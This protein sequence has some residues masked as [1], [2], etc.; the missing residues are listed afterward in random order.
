MLLGQEKNPGPGTHIIVGT[1]TDYPPYS[2]SENGQPT[3]FNVELTQAIAEVMGLD[4]EIRMRPWA[5]IRQSLED[6]KIQVVSG[7]AYSEDRARLVGFSPPYTII[8]HAIFARRHSPAVRSVEE[9][10]GKELI[11]MRGD[12]MH[13]YV[14]EAN[15]T[16]KIVV[17]DTQ[18][19]A[20]RLLASGQHDYA[21]VAKLPGLYWVQELKLKNVVTVGP[22]L[23]QSRYSYAVP[24]GDAAMLG[25][26]SEGLAILKQTGRYQELY[27]KWLGVL[28]PSGFS[29]AREFKYLA[30]ILAPI[31][32]ILAGALVWSRS[33]QKQVMSRTAELK[34]EVNER[35]RAQEELES[36]N[37]ALE[38]RVSERTAELSRLNAR[39]ELAVRGSN[40]GLWE[41][42]IPGGVY[43]NGRWN[44]IN[45]WEL[46]GYDR[47]ETPTTFSAWMDCVHA[48][49]RARLLCTVQAYL[50]GETNRY[51][52]EY[53]I[54][55]KDGQYRWVLS[56]GVAVRNAE[57]KP[58]RFIG[59][60]VDIT[61]RKQ[62]EAALRE[63]EERFRGFF[64]QTIVGIAQV[65]LDGRFVQ[66]NRRYCE[67]VGRS[68][69]ELYRSKMQEITHPDDLPRNLSLF[70]QLT[71]G[72]PSF[73]IEKRYIRPDGSLVWVNNCVSAL[74]DE[75]GTPSSNFAVVLD[76]TERKQVEEALRVAKARLDIAIRASN[77]GFTEWDMPDA[78][79]ARRTVRFIN[80][81]EQIGYDAANPPSS[82]VIDF[83]H[84]DD[85]DRLGREIEA[86]LYGQSKELE[87][88][89]RLRHKDGSYRWMLGR[90][91]AE[92]DGFGK[93]LRFTGSIVDITE[94]KRA[95]AALREAKE[96]A[97]SANR[98]KDEFLANVSHEIRT[99]MNAILGMTELV[100]DTP[101]TEDQRQCLKTAQSAADNL[102]GIIN[103]LLDF[104]K[105]EAGKL[106]LDAADFSLRAV[107]EEPLR[108][109]A[110]RAHRK[111]LELVCHVLPDVPDALVGDVGRLRQVL[112]NLIGNAIKFTEHGEVVLRV[113]VATEEPAVAA[114]AVMGVRFAVSDTGIGIPLANQEKI[115][116]AFE[117]EDTATTRKYGGTG[118]GLTIA[119]RLVALMGGAIAVDSAPGRGSTFSFTA[120]FARQARSPKPPT[121]RPLALI[122]D[123]QVLVVDDNA[124]NSRILV[125]W[126]RN[127]Q[128]EPTAAPDGATAMSALWQNVSLGRPHALVLLDARMPDMDGLALA[129]IIR[130]R[131]ELSACRIILLTSRDRPSDLVRCKELHIDA[132]LLKPVQP[133]EL[134]E[135]IYRVMSRA[136]TEAPPSWE[137]PA[138]PVPASVP[139]RILLAEDNDF[140][141]QHLGRLL[142]IRGHNV[143]LAKTGQEA[144]TLVQQEVFDLLLLDIHMPELDGFQVIKSLREREQSVGGHLPV[145]ALT[146]RVR[147]EDRQRCLA[148]GMDD[149]LSKPTRA[150]DLFQAIDR[151]LSVP[152]TGESSPGAAP[153]SVPPHVA[154]HTNL[155][156]PVV[157]LGAC[158]GIAKL[159]GEMCQNF[160]SN[161]PMLLAV[162][163]DALRDQD[164][165][166]LREASHKLYGTITA[167]STLAGEVVSDLEDRAADGQLEEAR[168]LVREIETM[169][170]ELLR[171]VDGLSIESLR[172]QLQ[173]AGDPLR[174]ARN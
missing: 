172:S 95:E 85:R 50:A 106:E 17:V 39:L 78:D 89:H 151:V 31:L 52:A 20:L 148:A 32:L 35:N 103:D 33:L 88:E 72:G 167:F 81:W 160:K 158:G 34:A 142:G 115:F 132:Y 117:Q 116:R 69:E 84:P 93:P 123:L 55:H 162:V 12:I 74:R 67:I 97:E 80:C 110:V 146:A 27:D 100:L 62:A 86:Y 125:E 171:Q 83:V 135:T 7:M 57:N 37:A 118:L 102:L 90:G 29:A 77:I 155:F 22:A 109:L 64:N 75:N 53:R 4:V 68:E 44:W 92:R 127:W 128:T 58:I 96:L 13:D 91:V 76:I 60:S 41:N 28:E 174:P 153:T 159:L 47:P 48:D 42:D 1:E 163:S 119:A 126:L 166:R 144:L 145:I 143:H 156:D 59:S 112:L 2:F 114:E 164:P 152:P 157:L 54:R 21:L 10:R 56:R 24:K 105:I 26:F 101:L 14:Q 16:S 131:A 150:A 70:G 71:Q 79:F 98:A 108:A 94:I 170:Q 82:H 136:D 46:L 15:L 130:Q 66:V 11:V 9:L 61:D 137:M 139:L 43:A 169:A 141:A 138:T 8:Q 161:V 104:A 168:P 149:Y 63:S 129:A 99:P 87:T 140:N 25:R 120:R 49:D 40:I 38:Q 134:L 5:E 19:A 65:D 147:K 113:S 73:E 18:A 51:E 121:A 133:D 36:L 107:L 23:L 165:A 122:K 111:G 173:V 154:D 45:M 3:G 6:R 124:T 30:L